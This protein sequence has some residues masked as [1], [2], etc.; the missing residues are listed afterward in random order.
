MKILL[1]LTL[2]LGA[3]LF[4]EVPSNPLEPHPGIDE[5]FSGSLAID[6]REREDGLV[7]YEIRIYNRELTGPF[8]APEGVHVNLVLADEKGICIAKTP[9][10]FG[11]VKRREGNWKDSGEK[12]CLLMAFAIRPP[13]EKHSMIHILWEEAIRTRE[14][15]YRLPGKSV[16]CEELPKPMKEDEEEQRKR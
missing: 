4:A 1:M 5:R 15:Y 11:V 2:A 12:P 10:S 7:H 6:R 16:V 9:A 3:S 14:R 8:A 13:L